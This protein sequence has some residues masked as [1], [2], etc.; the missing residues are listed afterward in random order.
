[1]CIRDRNVTP[2]KN[3]LPNEADVCML[4]CVSVICKSDDVDAAENVPTW[5]SAAAAARH[6]S[7]VYCSWSASCLHC[8]FTSM[9]FV[10]ES[11]VGG[12]RCHSHHLWSFVH[13]VQWSCHQR[14]W[15][16]QLF[17]T[18]NL[19]RC[20]GQYNIFLIMFIRLSNFVLVFWS[21][22]W[23]SHNVLKFRV[24]C[25]QYFDT[26]GWVTGQTCSL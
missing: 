7:A 25:L 22:L 11:T 17:W 8:G 18:W 24:Y 10:Q 1:M 23:W 6:C 20:S 2:D 16:R 14:K 26:V 4:I 12:M 9:W 15:G 5:A 3:S 21:N 13:H 19:V